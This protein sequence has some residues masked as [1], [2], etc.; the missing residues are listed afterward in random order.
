MSSAKVSQV[1]EKVNILSSDLVATQNNVGW[2]GQPAR[3]IDGNSNGQ[4]SAGYVYHCI[5]CSS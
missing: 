5:I 3:G 2:N 1:G 4:W